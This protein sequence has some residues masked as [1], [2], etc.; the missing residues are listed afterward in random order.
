MI[1]SI[2]TNVLILLPNQL[3][4]VNSQILFDYCSLYITMIDKNISFFNAKEIDT[5]CLC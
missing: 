2:K 3:N 1:A 4:I 5:T